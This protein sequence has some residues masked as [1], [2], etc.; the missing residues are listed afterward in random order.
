MSMNLSKM[1]IDDLRLRAK[2]FHLSLPEQR[3][4]ADLVEQLQAMI[5]R[6]RSTLSALII[7]YGKEDEEHK[8]IWHA[9]ITDQSYAK[10]GPV[11]GEIDYYRD[12]KKKLIHYLLHF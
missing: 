11:G 10:A 1:Q 7:E 5:D 6:Y 2:I 3:Q 12:E 8:G 9:E 4:L